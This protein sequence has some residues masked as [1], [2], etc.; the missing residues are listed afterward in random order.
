MFTAKKP[1]NRVGA[2]VFVLSFLAAATFSLGQLSKIRQNGL[3]WNSVEKLKYESTMQLKEK[4]MKPLTT[5]AL[6][7]KIKVMHETITK[8]A[9]AIM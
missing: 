8:E 7:G 3:G 6:S 5:G 1:V 9:K 2:V 4:Q